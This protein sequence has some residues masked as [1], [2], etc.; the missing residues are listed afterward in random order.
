MV[1]QWSTRWCADGAEPVASAIHLCSTSACCA[2]ATRTASLLLVALSR[3]LGASRA[4]RCCGA[5]GHRYLSAPGTGFSQLGFGG[6]AEGAGA[7]RRRRPRLWRRQHTAAKT[8]HAT[9]FRLSGGGLTHRLGL[10]AVGAVDVQAFQAPDRPRRGR[11][12]DARLAGSGARLRARPLER[13]LVGEGG[14]AQRSAFPQS[15]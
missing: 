2:A 3:L 12:L 11:V 13:R 1:R 10:L 6:A 9:T 5:T 7:H 4:R 15:I 8:A 14:A